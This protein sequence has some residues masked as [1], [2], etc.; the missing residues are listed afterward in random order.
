I[1]LG[2]VGS[3]IGATLGAA[4][5]RVL[6]L[7]LADLLPVDVTV[8]LDPG[9]VLLGLGLGIWVSVMFALMPLLTIRRVSPLRTLRRN[10]EQLPGRDPARIVAAI[11]LVV[12]VAGLAAVQAGRLRDGIAFTIALGVVVVILWLA[13]LALIRGLRRWFP[14]RWPYVWRQG[15]ANLYRPG[16][17]TVTVVLSLGFGAFLLS[18]LYL[19]QS[20]LL[21]DLNVAGVSAR[22]NMA[23]LD[24]QPDQRDGVLQQLREAGIDRVEAV[25]MIPM[26]I[27]SIKGKPVVIRPPSDTDSLSAD[28]AAVA[29]G[30]A[31]RREYR[32]SF[33]DSLVDSEELVAGTWWDGPMTDPDQPVDVSLEVDIATELHVTIGDEIVWDVQGLKIP[34]RVANTRKVD[35]ARFEPNF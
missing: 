18:T 30:W 15:L 3:L 31:M 20:N 32:S 27:A 4:L 6:P 28:S 5:Q 12:S 23:F 14:S 22:P 35:W 25:P 17:Q 34:S 26:R 16:N 11:A 1:G 19:V 21:R 13:S 33:R 2:A 29:T 8:A 9:A 10:V 7:V 24:I